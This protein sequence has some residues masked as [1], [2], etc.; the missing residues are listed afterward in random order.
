M[1]RNNVNILISF[2]VGFVLP[3]VQVMSFQSIA[4]KLTTKTTTKLHMAP[5]FDKKTQK[6]IPSSDDEMP[7]AGYDK[8]G[9]LL[10]HGP[11]PYFNRLFK[12][13]DYEQ[14]VLKFMAQDKCNR[15]EAQGN[16]DA[17]LA[18]PND[19]AYNRF[20]EQEKGF[21]VDYVTLNEAQILLTTVW[22][23]VVVLLGARA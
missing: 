9:T 21:K 6:W 11:I 13:S 2:L 3:S 23:S 1:I 14:G 18:N 5:K 15:M 22:G 7:S 17:Y 20:Q 19:W 10:R 12:E 4:T 16:M 8:I